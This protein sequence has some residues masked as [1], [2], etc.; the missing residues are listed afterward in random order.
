MNWDSLVSWVCWMLCAC[1]PSRA[2]TIPFSGDPS[3]PLLT[4]FM[5][6]PDGGRIGGIYLQHFHAADSWERFHCHR[7]ARMRSWILS[8][9]YTEERARSLSDAFTQSIF[10]RWEP[11]ESYGPWL[12]RAAAPSRMITHSRFTS[13]TMTG[14]DIHRV[15]RW[16]P[17]CWTIFHM[18]RNNG[19]KWGY[20]D[21]KGPETSEFGPFIPWREG[22][23]QRVASLETGKVKA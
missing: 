7:W 1:W 22:I 11:S 4:Q 17:L 12:A 3:R 8:G 5:V 15:E 18:R 13:Y 9:S 21:R 23:L 6:W 10:E 14:E 16:D 20:W 2:R 19:D